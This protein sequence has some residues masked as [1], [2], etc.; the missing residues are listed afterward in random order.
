MQQFS[1]LRS[2]WS[3]FVR[4]LLVAADASFAVAV[5]S[6][7]GV[8]C[9]TIAVTLWLRIGQLASV[10]MGASVETQPRSA[11][12]GQSVVRRVQSAARAVMEASGLELAAPTAAPVLIAAPVAMELAMPTAAPLP[13]VAPGVTAE[14]VV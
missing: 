13:T 12:T 9:Q 11:V 7:A 14:A 5:K 2:S 3:W 10:E 8:E 4:L 1:H 6:V